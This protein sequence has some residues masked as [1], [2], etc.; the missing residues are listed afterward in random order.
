MLKNIKEIK[1]W[2]E[3]KDVPGLTV[4]TYRWVEVLIR[5]FLILELD[6]AS[7][8]IP[9]KTRLYPLNMMLGGPQVRCERF[10]KESI[11]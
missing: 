3:S 5:S 8:F 7:C 4:K 11:S 10:G 9:G 2:I 1:K 6:V